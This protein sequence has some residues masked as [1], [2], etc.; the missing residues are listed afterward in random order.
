MKV[1]K[2]NPL[3]YKKEICRLPP[4]NINLRFY[5]AN[6]AKMTR[7]NNSTNKEQRERERERQ[8]QR[9]RERERGRERGTREKARTGKV[10]KVK[11]ESARQIKRERRAQNIGKEKENE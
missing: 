5:V 6:M 3:K 11:K 1:K 4:N 10:R 2:L 7:N 9:D 8:L